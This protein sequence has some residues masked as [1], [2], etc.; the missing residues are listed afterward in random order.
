VLPDFFLGA[1]YVPKRGE[2]HVPNYHKWSQNLSNGRK[3]DQM[4]IK[5][6]TSSKIYPVN[7]FWPENKPSGNHGWHQGDKMS[8]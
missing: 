2:I 8:L 5:Y 7:D 1:I 6:T 4:S 3:I